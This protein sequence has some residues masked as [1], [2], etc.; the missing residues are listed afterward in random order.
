MLHIQ[1]RHMHI[2][3]KHSGVETA[4]FSQ[5]CNMHQRH[6]HNVEMSYLRCVC[7]V[8]QHWK[9]K[10]IEVYMR[11]VIL[12]VVRVHMVTMRTLYVRCFSQIDRSLQKL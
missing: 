12:G 6:E 11:S 4:L 10:V 2:I 1:Y 7:V 8:R 3:V 9:V 5:L